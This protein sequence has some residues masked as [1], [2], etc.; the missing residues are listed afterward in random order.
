MEIMIARLV[1]PPARGGGEWRAGWEI[2]GGQ[3]FFC[4]LSRS[5]FPIPRSPLELGTGPTIG[6]KIKGLGGFWGGGGVEW[7]RGA[8]GGDEKFFK[9]PLDTPLARLTGNSV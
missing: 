9:F 1:R 5:P 4:Q 8:E 2:G 3:I 6:R 7:G